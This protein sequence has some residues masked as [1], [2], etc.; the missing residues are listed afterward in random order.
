M[1]L[2]YTSKYHIGYEQVWKCCQSA[3]IHLRVCS[4]SLDEHH[5]RLQDM[6]LNQKVGK[7]ELDHHIQ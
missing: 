3:I 4:G 5:K 2:I 1:F 7:D 6:N